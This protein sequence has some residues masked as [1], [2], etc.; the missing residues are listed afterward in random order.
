MRS[1]PRTS[2]SNSGGCLGKATQASC[3]TNRSG[4]L[5]N[6]VYERGNSRDACLSTLPS[7]LVGN[8]YVRFANDGRDNTPYSFT[9]TTDIQSVF[10]LL[11]DNRLDGT[12]GNAD[13]SPTTD[14]VLT[15][16]LQWVVDD[17]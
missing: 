13:G 2:A 15:G 14:P 7:Y 11:L 9:I 8:E 3:L 1:A 6:Y 10:Y 16:G 5:R 12:A 17:G 4:F